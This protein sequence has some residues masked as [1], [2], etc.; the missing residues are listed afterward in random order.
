[1]DPVV[2]CAKTFRAIRSG[3]F[4][5]AADPQARLLRVVIGQLE[6][7][8]VVRVERVVWLAPVRRNHAHRVLDTVW[9]A[10]RLEEFGRRGE[11]L[12]RL[13]QR[14]QTLTLEPAG[15]TDG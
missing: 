15:A 9:R 6:G 7:G 1:V 12:D 13:R 14:A 11:H 8:I 4:E 3:H 2:G 10:E 5:S